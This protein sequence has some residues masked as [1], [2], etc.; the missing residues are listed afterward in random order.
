MWVGTDDG[1]VQLTRDGGGSWTNLIDEMPGVAR[2]CVG[3]A[4]PRLE[5]TRAGEAFV[6]VED[7]RRDDWTPY[8]Y[9]TDDFGDSWRRI[10]ADIDGYALSVVQDPVE[11]GLVFIGTD[12]GLWFSVDGG[13]VFQRWTEGV[14]ATAVRDM[15]IHPRE[16][17]LVM[18]TFGRSFLVL[19]DI[20]PL[21]ERARS[22]SLPDGLH[23][24]PAM[25]GHQA[26]IHQQPG[27]VFPGDFL[28]QGENRPFG[29]R[30]RYWVPARDE[31]ASGEDSDGGDDAA[32]E[33]TIRIL[34]DGAHVRRLTGP[35]EPGVNDAWW[36]M[37]RAGERGPT[38]AAP[39]DPER[40]REPGGPL[41]LPGTYTVRVV[42]ESDSVETTIRVEP[43]PRAAFDDTTARRVD[44]LHDR[45]LE[46][47]RTATEA[48]DRIRDGRRSVE[49]VQ[50]MV[51]DRDGADADSLASHGRRMD[52]ALDTLY[53]S[54]AGEPIQGFRNQPDLVNSRLGAASRDLGGGRWAEPTE[55]A[56]RSLDRAD[57]AVEA[58]VTRVETFFSTRW[59]EY[60]AAVEAANLGPFGGRD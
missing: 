28:Y 7:H 24:Y 15:V 20:R 23:V 59:T 41:V 6:V 9:H 60:R 57:E 10:G 51:G 29:A 30:I 58:F 46:T 55:A 44:A 25:D 16:H 2:G 1:N 45:L 18:G 33:V 48:A 21:R 35:A 17:D 37:D 27:A 39:D 19:D 5:L 32:D 3:P 42:H 49:R 38:Q 53:W 50:D 47:R 43:D 11:P 8:V 26:V 40:A 31:G 13:E 52:A 22:G 56:M 4:D 54:L 36:R 12:R 14:P 34:R